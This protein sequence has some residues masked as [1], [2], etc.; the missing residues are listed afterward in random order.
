[1]YRKIRELLRAGQSVAV[2]TVTAS[3]GSTLR[4]VGPKMLVL[5]EG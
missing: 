2:A 4:E 5:R 3:R 1:M